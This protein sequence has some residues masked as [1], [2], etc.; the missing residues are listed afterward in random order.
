MVEIKN[1]KIFLCFSGH[2]DS[3]PGLGITN[4]LENIIQFFNL[5]YNLFPLILFKVVNFG[6]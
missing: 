1:A 2:P 5:V 3:Q 4:S 6:K